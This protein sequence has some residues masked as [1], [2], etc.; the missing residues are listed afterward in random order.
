MYI[1]M[2]N[3]MF[4]CLLYFFNFYLIISYFIIYNT[5]FYLWIITIPI[6]SILKYSS[7]Y[8]PRSLLFISVSHLHNILIPKFNLQ[9]WFFSHFFLQK[10][11]DDSYIIILLIHSYYVHSYVF[12]LYYSNWIYINSF[13][14][15][16]FIQ[17][18]CF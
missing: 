17:D 14:S 4:I 7:F 18:F 6:I 5:I 1:N 9:L 3:Q 16:I 2:I 11:Y 15:S 13:Y 8:K 12:K 10:I